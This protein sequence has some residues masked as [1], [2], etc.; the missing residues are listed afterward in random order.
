MHPRR[1][2]IS[3]MG[4][5]RTL[6]EELVRQIAAGEVVERPASALKELMEN[7][8]DAGAT[9]VDVLLDRGGTLAI[10]VIDDGNGIG[11]EDLAAAV[12]RHATSKIASLDDLHRVRSLG[13]RG[14]ALASICGVSRM[15]ITSRTADGR[16]AWVLRAAGADIEALEPAARDI[17]TTVE[18]DELYFNTPA[19]RKFLKSEST[20]FAHC[21]EVFRRLALS[22]PGVSLSL[23]HNGQEPRRLPAGALEDR[24][25][26]VLG[27]E[28]A[29]AALAV[30]VDAGAVRLHGMIAEPNFSRT[31]RDAQLFFVNGRFVRDKVLVH[32]VRQAYSDVLHQDRQPGYVLF[33]EMDPEAVDVNV[34]PAKTEVRFRDSQ[35]VHRLVF[36]AVER[37]LSR[38][39][40]ATAEGDAAPPVDR[41]SDAW[42]GA[43][44]NQA[45][46]GLFARAG[47][48][49]YNR[50]FAFDTPRPGAP[51]TD[52]YARLFAREPGA[53]Q[54]ADGPWTVPATPHR[55]A[56]PPEGDSPPLGFALAQLAGAYILAQNR[57]GL[58]VVDMHAAHERV[59]YERFKAD[60]DTK[61]VIAQPM[62]VPIGFEVD[63]L[64]AETL[65]KSADAL[66]G[67]GF[68][69]AL[70]GPRS[71][72]LR[73]LPA[74]TADSDPVSLARGVIAELREYGVAR[75]ATQRRNELLATMACHAAVRARRRLTVEEMNALLRDMERIE[76]ADQC[77][78]GRPTWFQVTLAELDAMFMRGR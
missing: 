64:E 43:S 32:A 54:A 76:R 45:P 41:T 55:E 10:R 35:A 42:L 58:V 71:A 37:E 52:V 47:A 26:A 74:W 14:E 46:G 4:R 16:S 18:V 40:A 20:E 9:H 53:T 77:N 61:P 23:R 66:T 57:S 22:R 15:R 6:S 50:S 12:E 29:R 1:P 21:E 44:A 17:G 36:H 31:A 25:K 8:F 60:L 28:F 27:P 70:V 5:I 59:M 13:F 56:A 39:R 72:A 30:D 38:T 11:H 2:S 68:E 48:A 19:R 3:T 24:I 73:A 49:P 67:L 33:L 65:E 62:L 63:A 78:H 7:A 69:I 75:V 34:H 51:S